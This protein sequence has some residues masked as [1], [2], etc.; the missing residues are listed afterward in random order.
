MSALNRQLA[1]RLGSIRGQITALEAEAADLRAKIIAT[2][3]PSLAGDEY[4]V[5]VK[6][7]SRWALHMPLVKARLSPEDFAAC[8]VTRALHVVS[9]HPREKVPESP[10]K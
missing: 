1:D 10:A 4:L 3:S 7:A 9:V 5:T 6:T 8:T 2:G